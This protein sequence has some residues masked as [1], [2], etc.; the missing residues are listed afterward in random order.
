MKSKWSPGDRALIEMAENDQGRK[1]YQMATLVRQ[2]W[3][4]QWWFR[5]DGVTYPEYEGGADLSFCVERWIHEPGVLDKL[6]EI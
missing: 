2:D 3:S 6:A 4:G 1:D 5:L